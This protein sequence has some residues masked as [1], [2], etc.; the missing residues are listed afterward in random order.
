LLARLREDE[1][2]ILAEN[3]TDAGDAM[4]LAGRLLAAFHTSVEIEGRSILPRANIGIAT[5][6]AGSETSDELLRNAD[7]AM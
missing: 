7:V 1:F 2:A 5:T 6:V 3:L 4:A